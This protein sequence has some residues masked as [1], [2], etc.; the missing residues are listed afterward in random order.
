MGLFVRILFGIGFAAAGIFLV[1]KTRTLLEFFGTIDWAEMKLGGGGSNLMYKII[2]L[3]LIFVG[4][5]I[6]TNL[7]SAFLQATLG[8]L[9]GFRG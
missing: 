7:W 6:A 8:S 3:I 4:F 9:F 5:M 1:V 2:G